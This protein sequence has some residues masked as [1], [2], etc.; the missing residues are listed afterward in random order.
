MKIVIDTSIFIDYSRAST[1]LYQNL[2][3][4]AVTGKYD[5]YIP[6]IVL[7]EF[8]SGREMNK[9]INITNANKLFLGINVIDL[10]KSIAKSAGE[11]VR[12]DKMVGFDA[13]IAA[14]ALKISAQ[15]ATNNIKHFSKV[16]NLKLW[17]SMK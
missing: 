17:K 1:G 16:K 11:L 4:G 13:I 15:V 14:T 12:N 7:L 3:G 2:I 9:K 8:W 10:T 6:T 5:L